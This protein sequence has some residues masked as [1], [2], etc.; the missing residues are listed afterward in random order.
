M[1]KLLAALFS[2]FVVLTGT[3]EASA[4]SITPTELLK[5]ISAQ[6]DQR[7][8]LISF[9][10]S[11]CGPCRMELPHLVKI[12]NDA[13]QDLCVIGIDLDKDVSAGEVF[14]KDMGISFPVYSDLGVIAALFGVDSI[15]FTAVYSDKGKLLFARAGYMDESRINNLIIKAKTQ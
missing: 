9:F 7:P 1:K 14:C 6:K 3:F 11:W 4:E 8:V 15:P 10:A 5:L 2:A 12:A 13:G